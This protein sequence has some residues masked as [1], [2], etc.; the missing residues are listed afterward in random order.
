MEVLNQSL[1]FPV[2]LG[3]KFKNDD[4]ILRVCILETIDAEIIRLCEKYEWMVSPD[5][6][7]VTEVQV[8]DLKNPVGIPKG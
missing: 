3:L 2:F 7:M 6:F 5:D 8:E 1:T 4:E